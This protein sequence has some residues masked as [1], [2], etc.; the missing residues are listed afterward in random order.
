MDR[1]DLVKTL[2]GLNLGDHCSLFYSK[3]DKEEGGTFF[4]LNYITSFTVEPMH[5]N[6]DY[7]DTTEFIF[8]DDMGNVVRLKEDE[9]TELTVTDS[10]SYE[11]IKCAV[12]EPIVIEKKTN[13]KWNM[14]NLAGWF[15]CG[16]HVRVKMNNCDELYDC[17]LIRGIYDDTIIELTGV[18][19]YCAGST[20]IELSADSY[21]N[22]RFDLLCP[23]DDQSFPKDDLITYE[24]TKAFNEKAL[25]AGEAYLVYDK[26][27]PE[28]GTKRI[29]CL[30]KKIVGKTELDFVKICNVDKLEP[31]SDQFTISLNNVINGDYT[32]NQLSKGIGEYY[33]RKECD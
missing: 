20:V 7:V 21:A 22:G 10:Y 13:V 3:K 2:K 33:D 17:V 1:K 4:N 14:D 16:K 12:V 6:G 30:L 23:L 25:K 31:T 24:T 19:N 29:P 15:M 26:R 32:I 11:Q 9:I 18:A 28:L 8:V 5:I 27:F